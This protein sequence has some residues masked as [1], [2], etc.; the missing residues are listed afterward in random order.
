MTVTVVTNGLP[1]EALTRACADLVISFIYP[2]LT[3]LG[4]ALS[5]DTRYVYT[6]LTSEAVRRE[7][8]WHKATQVAVAGTTEKYPCSSRTSPWVRQLFY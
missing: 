7:L 3:M 4:Y 5:A 1:F 2:P 8:S 6:S